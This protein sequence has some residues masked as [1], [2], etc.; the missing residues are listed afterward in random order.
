[1]TASDVNL[2]AL[3]R[4][5]GELR[6]LRMAIVSQRETLTSN[7]T[8][9]RSVWSDVTYIRHRKHLDEMLTEIEAFERSCDRQVD[10]LDRKYVAGMNVLRSG[11]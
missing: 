5:S 3:R 9:I 2:D 11:R 4:F 1:M 8:D 7:A 10:F 6:E